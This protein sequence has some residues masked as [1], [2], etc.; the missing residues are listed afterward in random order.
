MLLA[1]WH[2]FGTCIFGSLAFGTCIFQVLMWL[3]TCVELVTRDG[4][5]SR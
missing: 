2:Y 4:I 5:L 3:I 1:L